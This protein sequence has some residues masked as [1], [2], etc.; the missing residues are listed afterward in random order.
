VVH[1]FN[2]LFQSPRGSR[3]A[4]FTVRINENGR[5]AGRGLAKDAANITTAA[6][7]GSG[8]VRA[9]TNNVTGRGHVLASAIAQGDVAAAGGVVKERI[10]T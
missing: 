7:V 1:C 5:S 3:R 8:D 9:D 6:Y 2:P 10:R 4:K